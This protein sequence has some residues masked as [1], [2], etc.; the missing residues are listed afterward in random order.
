MDTLKQLLLKGLRPDLTL[1]FDADP[2]KALHRANTRNSAST[3]FS[4]T[5]FDNE[6]LHFHKK[7]RS[8]FLRI[9]SAEP[10]RICLVNAEETMETV[11]NKVWSAVSGLLMKAGF[12]GEKAHV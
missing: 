1:L 8:E 7:V 6:S 10:D 9:A 12:F 3:D 2:E 5:R 11:A 4:E